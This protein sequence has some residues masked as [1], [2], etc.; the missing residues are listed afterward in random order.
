MHSFVNEFKEHLFAANWNLEI[1]RR[2]YEKILGARHKLVNVARNRKES[3]FITSK[4]RLMH[5]SQQCSYLLFCSIARVIGLRF[6]DFGKVI[7]TLWQNFRVSAVE[8]VPGLRVGP[9]GF[10]NNF[11]PQNT[12][13]SWNVCLTSTCETIKIKITATIN[14]LSF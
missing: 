9:E 14:P 4:F 7:I 12:K 1:R 13:K 6:W 8:C 10:S 3:E 5:W 11:Q 2:I